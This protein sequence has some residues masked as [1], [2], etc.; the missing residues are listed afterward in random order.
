LSFLQQ[1]YFQGD[2]F[3]MHEISFVSYLPELYSVPSLHLL[4]LVLL[5]LFS[6]STKETNSISLLKKQTQSVKS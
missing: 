2:N 5:E 4:E 3:L 6:F 1:C